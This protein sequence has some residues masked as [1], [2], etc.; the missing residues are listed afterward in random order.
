MSNVGKEHEHYMAQPHEQPDLELWTQNGQTTIHKL[1]SNS[2]T[3]T[4]H[5]QLAVYRGHIATKCLNSKRTKPYQYT[6]DTL[7]FVIELLAH[8]C[9]ISVKLL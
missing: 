1:G 5:F 4:E 3:Y 6:A 7:L 8:Y 9:P 2:A